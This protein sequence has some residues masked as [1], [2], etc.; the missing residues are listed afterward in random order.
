M[1]NLI[2]YK[3]YTINELAQFGIGENT[4]RKWFKDGYLQP[5]TY[6]NNI[7]KFKYKNLDEACFLIKEQVENDKSNLNNLLI[8]KLQNEN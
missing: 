5:Y 1:T 6:A 2:E 7:P 4:L 3:L 8:K